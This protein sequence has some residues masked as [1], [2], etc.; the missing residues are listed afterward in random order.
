MENR[1]LLGHKGAANERKFEPNL[2]KYFNIGPTSSLFSD[3]LCMV[4]AVLCSISLFKRCDQDCVMFSKPVQ[5]A[6]S[7]LCYVQ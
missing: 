7:G 5:K 1:T 3:R 6:W 2:N 4:R